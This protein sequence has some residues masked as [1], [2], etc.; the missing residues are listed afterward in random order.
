MKDATDALR[1]LSNPKKF[2][3]DKVKD[4]ADFTKWEP[5][6]S[7]AKLAEDRAEAAKKIHAASAEKATKRREAEAA[8]Q[9]DKTAQDAAKAAAKATGSGAS[10]AD[11]TPDAG[12]AAPQADTAGDSKA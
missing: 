8:A 9:A 2:G 10:Q 6:S 11:A 12:A 3:L 1:G 7:T 4:A 5:G